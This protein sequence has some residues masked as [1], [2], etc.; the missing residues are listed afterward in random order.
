MENSQCDSGC[1][2]MILHQHFNLPNQGGVQILW[3]S[4]VS[5]S[6]FHP[7]Q[8]LFSLTHLVYLFDT[9]G[10]NVKEFFFRVAS[11]A[12]ETNVLAELEK[13]GPRQIGNVVSEYL[14]NSSAIIETIT[15]V[16]HLKHGAVHLFQG[17]TALQTVCTLH[18]R[19][20]SQTAV[21]KDG[22]EGGV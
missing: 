2:K 13:S 15:F 4:Y 11:L 8:H 14:N 19:R 7:S 17:L 10:E 6:K 20:N 16:T 1:M 22:G 3:R 18:R 9:S 21:S 12:F 5:V